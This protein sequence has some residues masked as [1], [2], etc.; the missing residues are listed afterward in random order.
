MNVLGKELQ[1]S[2]ILEGRK[3]MAHSQNLVASYFRNTL[4]SLTA[5]PVE[6]ESSF[7]T[8][9]FQGQAVKRLR[10]ANGINVEHV[11]D[12]GV[13]LNGGFSPHFTPQVLIV[14]LVE[15]PM[16]IVGETHHSSGRSEGML[17][18]L[19]GAHC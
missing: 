15:K 16:E 1:P 17:A 19:H 12:S 18:P 13:S 6:K 11:L 14:S 9:I 7:P 8:I 3:S 5:R 10:S 2:I 4:R